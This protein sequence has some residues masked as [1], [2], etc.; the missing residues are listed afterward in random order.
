[1]SSSRS[2]SRRRSMEKPSGQ[3]EAI[4][5]PVCSRIRGAAIRHDKIATH[6]HT[7]RPTFSSPYWF[8]LSFLSSISLYFF[9]YFVGEEEEEEEEKRRKSSFLFTRLSFFIYLYTVYIFLSF[10][11][12]EREEGRQAGS[13]IVSKAKEKMSIF[14]VVVGSTRG[15]IRT[16]RRQRHTCSLWLTMAHRIRLGDLNPPSNVPFFFT[17]RSKH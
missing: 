6:T 10:Y 17:T 5:F 8:S 2:S 14:S 1:M 3:G 13:N 11:L 16:S 15:R 9:L 12:E 7:T 4:F